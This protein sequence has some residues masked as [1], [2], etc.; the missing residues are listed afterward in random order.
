M[1]NVVPST[2]LSRRTRNVRYGAIFLALLGVLGVGGGLFLRSFPLTVPSNPAY[3]AYLTT[4]NA[5]LGLGVVLFVL[6][7]L[8]FLRAITWKQ[9]NPLAQQVG[10]VFASFLDNKYIYIRNVSKQSI[11]YVDAIVVGTAG[12]LVL[13][14]TDKTGIY[15]NEGN[16]WMTQQDKGVWSPLT[17]SPTDEVVTD[18]K[19]VRDFLIAN[20]LKDVQVF[21]AVVF[22]HAAPKTVVTVSNAVVPVAQLDE[23]ELKLLNNYLAKRDRMDIAT[24]TKVAELIYL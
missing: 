5:I 11:G 24:V 14:I 10:E 20:K 13:R 7:V 15:Y 8:L 2:A 3:E 6:A 21:G 4:A 18:I 1:Q 9:E 23:L 19:K 17:W 12:V 16:K 22:T